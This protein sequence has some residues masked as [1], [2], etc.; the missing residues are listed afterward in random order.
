V[1]GTF[2]EAVACTLDVEIGAD[3]RADGAASTGDDP[4][5]SRRQLDVTTSAA[6]IGSRRRS[7]VLRIVVRE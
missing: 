2:A 7:I 1:S 3:A 6:R 5:G 4:L